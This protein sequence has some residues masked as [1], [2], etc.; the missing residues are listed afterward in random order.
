MPHHVCTYLYELAQKF[1]GFYERNRVIGDERQDVRLTLVTL[2]AD[3]LKNG[4][5]L[6]GISAPNKM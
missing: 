3:T 1:N 2:Y 4:L 6:L 5:N